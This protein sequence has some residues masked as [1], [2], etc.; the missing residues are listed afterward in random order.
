MISHCTGSVSWNSSTRTTSK[1]SR[2]RRAGDRAAVGVGQGLAQA[3]QHVV[4][5]QDLAAPLAFPHVFA[6]GL[7][8]ATSE[9]RRV[10][11]VRQGRHQLGV[12]VIEC[13]ARDLH[14]FGTSEL[15]RVGPGGELAQEE[16]VDHLFHEVVHILDQRDLPVHVPGGPEPIED[17]QAE[18]V[19]RL[20]GGRV[21][22]GDG[23]AQPVTACCDLLFRRRR[24]QLHQLV[25]LVSAGAIEHVDQA[26]E[27]AHQP[28]S[29]ALAQF[30]RRHARE[31]D[32][33][34]P[35]DRQDALRHVARGQGGDG[36]G[37]AG[38][39]ARLQQRH[40]GREIPA[41]VERG[42]ARRGRAGHVSTI[43]S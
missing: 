14:R 37:L 18:S 42:R 23:L 30:A 21:E 8:K 31:R 5:G 22:V 4:V 34:Q 12:G 6:Y 25:V 35:V 39:G 24:Q 10:L 7:G 28:L 36:E 41:H 29:H 2:S 38:S 15:Q 9:G 43:C 20:D 1:R 3:E 19:G 33:E 27:G 40:A 17:L 16:V 11:L 13:V 26:V 32:D